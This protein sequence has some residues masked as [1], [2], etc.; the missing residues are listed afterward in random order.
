MIK[1]VLKLCLFTSI[2]FILVAILVLFLTSNGIVLELIGLQFVLLVCFFNFIL[3]GLIFIFSPHFFKSKIYRD[4]NINS[5]NASEKYRRDF[6]GNVSHELKTPI[7]NIQGYVETLIEGALYDRS[8]NKKYLKRT[9]KSVERLIYIVKD[10]ES[11]SQLE[12]EGLNLKIT[13]W[14]VRIINWPVR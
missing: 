5:I 10:L 13:N 14:L 1:N 12:T 8:V 9:S 4:Q 6:L 3:I 7:F 11:I 2:S